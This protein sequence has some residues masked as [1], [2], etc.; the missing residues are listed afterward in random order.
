MSLALAIVVVA[1]TAISAIAVLA[2][3]VWGAVKDGQDQAASE[4]RVKQL[5]FAR[6]RIARRR[7]GRRSR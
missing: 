7:P 3:F 5:A 1:L 6:A 4:A 2:L